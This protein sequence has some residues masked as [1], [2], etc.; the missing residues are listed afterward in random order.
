MK[1][2]RSQHAKIA[3]NGNDVAQFV[4]KIL[5]GVAN[6]RK[7]ADM[8]THLDYDKSLL[9][10]RFL[11]FLAEVTTPLLPTFENIEYE[12]GFIDA[13]ESI[14]EEITYSKE[15][16]NTTSHFISTFYVLTLLVNKCVDSK[17]LSSTQDKVVSS[18][19]KMFQ[20]QG[21][22]AND[23]F[24]W[25]LLMK[26]KMD[27]LVDVRF[28]TCNNENIDALKKALIPLNSIF[29]GNVNG[30]NK[31]HLHVI[32]HH[33]NHI[34]NVLAGFKDKQSLI[35]NERRGELFF[36]VYLQ[37]I[38]Y[39]SSNSGMDVKPSKFTYAQTLIIQSM[40]N[41]V[42]FYVDYLLDCGDKMNNTYAPHK[43]VRH[44]LFSGDET[45]LLTT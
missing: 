16:F 26:L 23:T 44:T 29:N 38:Q 28:N 3:W 4:A 7:N 20:Y 42:D 45:F 40:N 36:G 8:E 1:R 41:F 43:M 22:I 30:F 14:V 35:K 27:L 17:R 5:D 31:H 19:E 10:A 2:Q 13:L 25:E 9:V 12:I 37:M 15:S 18:V 33:A 6:H 32:C 24:S 39:L 11:S 34:R 21:E